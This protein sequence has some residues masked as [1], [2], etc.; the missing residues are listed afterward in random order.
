MRAGPGLSRHRRGPPG[1]RLR[2]RG[3]DPRAQ[4]RVP[5]PRRADRRA[6]LRSRRGRALGRPA[7]ARRHRHLPRAH[8]RPARGDRPRRPPPDRH[9][10]RDRRRRDAGPPGRADALGQRSDPPLRLHRPRRAGPTS[11][12]RRSTNA[13]VGAKVAIVSDKPQTTRR[14][15]RGVATGPDWQLVLVDLPG[16]PAP[17]RRAHR[18]DAAAGRARA[19][20]RRRLPVRG[21]R[22]AGHRS[23][24][25]LHR[26]AAERRFRA[27]RDRRQ[28]DRPRSTTPRTA[29]ALQAAAEL[30]VADEIFPVSARTGAG[31][32]PLVDHLVSLLPEGP[33]YFEP[34]QHS[35]QSRN[36]C[37]G[38][39]GP[40]A[41]AGPHPRGGAARGRG[42]GRG[43]RRRCA[44]I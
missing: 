38:R 34:G 5:R 19:R 29:A 9:G 2:R 8:R 14:A 27:G 12:S 15:I 6:V 24:R 16:R 40:R 43:D 10:P 32:R 3:A 33:F 42:P 28:Q 18:A 37:A 41:G 30:E 21:Q 36:R 25:S 22:R 1:D 4:P 31:M 13:I 11:A 20:G 17:A 7:G 26:R 44:T 39:A 35:D 23:R